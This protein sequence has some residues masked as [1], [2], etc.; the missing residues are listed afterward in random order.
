MPAYA[1]L[2]VVQAEGE[3]MVALELAWREFGE[4]ESSAL[5]FISVPWEVED[6]FEQADYY[7]EGLLAQRV[8]DHA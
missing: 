4:H 6:R 3:D 5:S 7:S 8:P 2:V 1:M